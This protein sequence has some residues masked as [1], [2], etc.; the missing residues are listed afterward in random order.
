[1]K[2]QIG[3][4]ITFSYASKR[5]HDH[6]PKCLILHPGWR[7]PGTNAGF[8][9]HALNLN[10][11][12]DDETNLLRMII[13]PGF[14]LKYFENMVKK[15]PYTAAEYSRVIGSAA[16]ANITSPHDFY[17]RVIRPF[18]QPRGWDPYRLYDPT[19]MLNTAVMQTQRQMLGSQ[20][21]QFFGSNPKDHGKDEKQIL[22]DLAAKKA[23]A[24]QTG[25]GQ[26]T[27][28]EQKFIRMLKGKSLQ[29]FQ[30]YKA[31][32]QNM[33]GP[34]MNNRTPNFKGNQTDPKNPP[35]MSDDLE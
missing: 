30:G 35:W 23:A 4:I 19:K 26:L 15:N 6:F 9:V 28:Q 29:L 27:P 18:I 22:S 21:L 34:Q 14:Q 31:K 17:I 10:Y 16:N 8:L 7:S 33:K 3:S 24:I 5:S 25:A 2:L 13:D 32:F 20:D 11:L 1:M 12:T